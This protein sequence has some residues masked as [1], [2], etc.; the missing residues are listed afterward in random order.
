MVLLVKVTGKGAHP[1]LGSGRDRRGKGVGRTM[2][3]NVASSEQPT[4]F[5][6]VNVMV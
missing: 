4:L 6:A 5:V 1:T 3:G 2:I